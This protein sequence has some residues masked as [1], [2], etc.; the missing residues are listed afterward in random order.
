MSVVGCFCLGFG[1]VIGRYQA[2]QFVLANVGGRYYQSP[3]PQGIGLLVF[4]RSYFCIKHHSLG[5]DLGSL[6]LGIQ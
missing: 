4:R 1:R 5:S 3:K 6:H 2:Y